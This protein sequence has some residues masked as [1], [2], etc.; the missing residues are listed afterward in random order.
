[1]QPEIDLQLIH[2][3][4]EE[5]QLMVFRI[6]KEQ[7]SNIIKHA[8]CT[9]A[10]IMLILEGNKAHL[11]VSDNGIEFDKEKQVLRSMGFSIIFNRIDAYN[12]K[13]E[14]V[15]SPGNGCALVIA[16]PYPL[17]THFASIISFSACLYKL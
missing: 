16:L 5:Q 17:S 14:V 11:V 13:L 7:T 1:V 6:V 4:T 8:R 15:I 2:R 3:L 9:Q 10:N 12:G